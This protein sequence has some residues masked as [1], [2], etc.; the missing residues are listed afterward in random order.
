MIGLLF[1]F[2]S[3]RTSIEPIGWSRSQ[4]QSFAE[5]VATQLQYQPNEDIRACVRKLGGQVRDDNWD[6]ARDTGSIK[7]AGPGAFTIALSP[8]SGGN[9]ARFT[10]AH[11][12]GHYFLH[13]RAG[14]IPLEVERDGDGRPEWEANW[15]AAAFLMP[16]ASFR[17]KVAQGLTTAELAEAFGVSEAAVEVRQK[18]I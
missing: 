6:S 10:I 1:P 5:Q 2:V 14:K 7:V 3:T 4:V 11:E 18:T 9:R 17:A 16:A 13:S 15:F 8:L 12:L